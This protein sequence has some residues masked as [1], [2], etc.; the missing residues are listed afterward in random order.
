MLLKKLQIATAVLLLAGLTALGIG[1]LAGP[2]AV[3][4]PSDK[5]DT[6]RPK[7]PAEGSTTWAVRDTLKG[8]KDRVDHLTFSPDGKRL[9]TASYDGTVKIWDVTTGKLLVTLEGHE[10]QVNQVAF[11]P[12]GKTVAT[13]GEDKTVRI[14]DV[15]KG[16]E[17]QKM[18]HD[19]PVYSVLFTRD[20]KTLVAGGGVNGS[21]DTAELRL[22]DP[23]TGTE[24]RPFLSWATPTASRTWPSP[25]A[26]R[27]WS[28]AATTTPSGPGTG[29][30]RS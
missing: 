19:A 8:H 20:G 30:A 26:T 23:A 16:T 27:S 22:W 2:R 7:K 17:L 14:W 5:K 25:P 24:G 15:A 12:D 13:A 6:D 21:G 11:A 10:G 1:S 4:R 9:A 3:A 29:T 28:R 18:V